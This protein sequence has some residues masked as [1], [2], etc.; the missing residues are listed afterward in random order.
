MYYEIDNI[1]RVLTPTSLIF[2]WFAVGKWTLFAPTNDAFAKVDAATMGDL[3]TMIKEGTKDRPGSICNM[4]SWQG[5]A[6]VIG[7]VKTEVKSGLPKIKVT[8]DPGAAKSV[9]PPE[10]AGNHPRTLHREDIYYAFAS[11]EPLKNLG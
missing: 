6:M 9:M 10:A 2:T 7:A 5:Q 1:S 11:G 3:I 8:V 4:A